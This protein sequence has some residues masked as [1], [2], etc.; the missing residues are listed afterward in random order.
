MAG[1]LYFNRS[2]YADH[3][4]FNDAVASDTDFFPAVLF[5]VALTR[6]GDKKFSDTGNREETI[7]FMIWKSIALTKITDT[8]LCALTQVQLD[9]LDELVLS[10]TLNVLY[11]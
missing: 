10:E 1:E 5:T 6:Q 7:K 3:D 8:N 2:F 9:R 4:A 11:Y